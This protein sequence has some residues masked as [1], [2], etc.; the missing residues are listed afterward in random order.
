MR[1]F[2]PA[3][4]S[5]L[6]VTALTASV[7]ASGAAQA[8]PLPTTA[9][10]QN[11]K[12]TTVQP[13]LFG[14]HVFNL[15]DGVW[16]TIPVGSIR[17]WD[18]QTTW[19]SVE[20]AQNVFDWTKLDKAVSTAENNGVHDILK[21]LAGTPLWATD[22]P[23]AGGTAGVLP[24][25]AGMPKN[26]ADWDDW[27]LQVVNRYKG[28][29]TSYQPWNEA[30]LTTFST[31]TPKQMADLTKRAYDII[32]A[33]DPAAKVVAPSTGTRLG[34]PFNKFYPAYLAELKAR[35]W[36]VDVFAAHTYPASLGTPVDRAL[37]AQKWIDA[38]KAAGAPDLPLWDTENNF[39]LAGPGPQN[40][41]QDII[42]NQAAEWAAR[43]YLDA[44]RLNI[45][46]VYWYS[47]GPELDLVGIQM[48]NGSPAAI[49]LNTLQAW[50]VGSKFTGCKGTD[51]VVCGFTKANGGKTQ[52][53]WA[54]SGRKSFTIPK[55]MKQICQLDSVCTD[56]GP[57][58][59]IRIS[60][61]V[62]FKP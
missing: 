23:T 7:L 48:N 15:Q 46:R 28:R 56:K 24:G 38:L 4:L 39:G 37:L 57:R 59:K 14:M 41:D 3:A 30:N 20:T 21:V 10:T 31:G 5:L 34:G 13:T 8:A 12:G 35:N 60:G 53:V 17:L 16:P 62:L 43:T 27:V 54:Q 42:G 40:P 29:I 6:A 47:W 50:I 2:R 61:P 36:P 9:P 25:G 32:K 55:R 58:N 52:V 18:N 45:S 19:S 51:R 33:V 49:A 1:L 11:L 22:N 26:F 44:L